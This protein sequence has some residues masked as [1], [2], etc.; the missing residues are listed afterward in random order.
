[1]SRPRGPS[2]LE[3]GWGGRWE[4]RDRSG[5]LRAIESVSCSVV[6]DSFWAHVA[7]Q[8]PLSMEFSRQDY[9]SGWPFPSPG[10]L[11]NPGVETWVSCIAGVFFASWATSEE[12]GRLFVEAVPMLVLVIASAD[13]KIL[14][15]SGDFTLYFLLC[16]FR[17]F[18]NCIQKHIVASETVASMKGWTPCHE[19]D[20]LG[21]RLGLIW[22]LYFLKLFAESSVS[23]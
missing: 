3:A 6:S 13:F 2:V 15:G 1:M 5:L 4:R 17:E 16:F 20:I 23:V 12:K 8:A 18:K 22:E 9:W 21:L 11:P 7:H 10:D 19:F 14:R